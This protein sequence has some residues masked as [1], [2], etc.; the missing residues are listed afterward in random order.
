MTFK[1]LLIN[2]ILLPLQNKEGVSCFYIAKKIRINNLHV[3]H[4]EFCELLPEERE[5][6]KLGHFEHIEKALI[7]GQEKFKYVRL[8]KHC[9]KF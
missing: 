6:I 5:R 4:T 8:C 3:I 9:C 2:H 7:A 1:T